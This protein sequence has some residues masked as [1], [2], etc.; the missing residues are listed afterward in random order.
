MVIACRGAEKSHAQV[1]CSTRLTSNKPK[2]A[3]VEKVGQKK[4]SGALAPWPLIGTAWD[5][6]GLAVPT[7]TA[8]RGFLARLICPET[9]IF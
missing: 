7:K 3:G 1:S 9:V 5:G 6:V 8:V 4:Y 2:R